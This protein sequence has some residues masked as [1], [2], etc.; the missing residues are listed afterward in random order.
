MTN[1]RGMRRSS[2]IP[3]IKIKYKT[4]QDVLLS[5]PILSIATEEL[6]VLFGIE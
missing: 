2:I 6:Q 5:A 3:A 4:R 1:M